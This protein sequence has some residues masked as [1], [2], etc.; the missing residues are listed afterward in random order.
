VFVAGTPGGPTYVV[1]QAIEPTSAWLEHEA[2]VIRALAAEP[3]LASHLPTVVHHDADAGRLVLRTPGNAHDWS[4][5]QR[6]GRFPRTPARVLGHVLA[7]LHGLAPDAVEKRPPGLAP[8]WALSLPEPPHGLLLELSVGA[9]DLL[10]RIQASRPLCDRLCGLGEGDGALIH[11]DLRWDNCLA[12]PAP[13][14]ARRTRVTIIDWELAGSGEAEFDVGTVLAEYLRSWVTSI[15][16]ID[17]SDPGKLVRR[18]QRPLQRMQPAVHAF[19]SSYCLASA[20]RPALCRVIEL[21]AV[22]LIQAAVERSQHYV[23]PTAHVVALVQ[24]AENLLREPEEAA[25]TLF[26]LGD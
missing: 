26:A 6:S 12:V 13:G 7:A 20:R 16:I 4:A 10:G 1:K 25:L 23:R 18:A 5:H 15:P 2:A 3:D 14:S 9:L 17:P 19:W 24:L 11:G 22:R 21:A 8:M